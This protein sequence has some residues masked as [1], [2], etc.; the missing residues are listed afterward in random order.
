MYRS[1]AVFM[2][3]LGLIAGMLGLVV[4][5]DYFA[6]ARITQ[7]QTEAMGSLVISVTKGVLLSGLFAVVF[8]PLGIMGLRRPRLG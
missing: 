7:D 5:N 2:L 1:T 6:L 8:I 4:L 3:L